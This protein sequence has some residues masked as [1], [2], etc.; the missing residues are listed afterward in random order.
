MSQDSSNNRP[1][2]VHPGTQLAGMYEIDSL[3]A[4]GGIDRKSVV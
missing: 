4:T 3:L 2:I 1:G